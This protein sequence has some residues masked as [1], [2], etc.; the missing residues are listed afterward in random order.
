[1]KRREILNPYNLVLVLL[2]AY[3]TWCRMNQSAADVYATKVYP[4]LSS[5]LSRLSSVIS[6]SLEEILVMVFVGVVV[7]IIID[8]IRKKRIWYSVLLREVRWLL[9]IYIWFYIGWGLNYSRST[10]PQRLDAPLA[11]YDE[12]NFKSFLSDYSDQ[13]NAAYDT[14]DRHTVNL[15]NDIRSFYSSLYPATGLCKPQKWQG[16]KTALASG[17]FSKVGVTGSMGPFLSESLLNG[18]MPDSEYPFTAAHEFAHL[19]G[20]SSEA[21]ANYFAFSYCCASS[22]PSVRY[23][24]YLTLLGNILRNARTLLPEE[25]YVRFLDTLRPEVKDDFNERAQF[26][27]DKYSKLL[28]SIQDKLYNAY[29]KG[30]GISSGTKNYDEVVSYLMSGFKI[31]STPASSQPQP[32]ASESEIELVIDDATCEVLGVKVNEVG[33]YY[34]INPMNEEMIPVEGHSIRKITPTP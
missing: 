2:F 5:I 19:M 29:L 27:A 18:D 8:G 16:P 11:Q 12:E 15:L 1:M 10:L 22:D 23:S 30:N 33:G 14:R 9:L 32:E 13:I 25:E 28:G 24:G 4:L 31:R 34:I 26:W 21:E 7:L 17:F 20:V 6:I 3:V